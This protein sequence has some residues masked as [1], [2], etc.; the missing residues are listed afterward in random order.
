[1]LLSICAIRYQLYLN[2]GFPGAPR[3]SDKKKKNLPANAGSIRDAALIPF[4][5]KIPWSRKWQPTPVFL[6]GEF[7]GQRSLAGYSP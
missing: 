5:G 3:C 2:K 4:V 1:M 7:H 6:P